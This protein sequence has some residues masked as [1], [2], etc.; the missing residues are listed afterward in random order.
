MAAIIGDQQVEE[1]T[2]SLGREMFARMRGSNPRIWQYA[3][4]LERILN[5]CMQD[6]W[7][8]VQAFRFVDVLPA[9]QNDADIARHLKEYFVLPEHAR[10]G[11]SRQVVHSGPE[12]ADQA[13]RELDANSSKSWMVR[14]VS[15]LMNFRSLHSPLAKMFAFSARTGAAVMAGSFIPGSNVVEAERALRKL[16]KK[17]QA[18]T[19]D[20]LG[21]AAVS[22]VEAEVYHQIYMDLISELPRHAAEWSAVPL[23]DEGD[24]KQIPRVNVSVK[25][26]S[27]YPGF[28]PIAAE[29]AKKRAKEILRPLL[30][31][32]MEQGVHLHIDMEHYAIKDLTLD[33][34]EELFMEDE[35]RDYPHFGI[36]L[37]AYLKDGDKDAARTVEYAQRRGTP[38]WVRLV[39]GAYWD[40]ETVWAAQRHWPVPV[41]EQ[42]WESD[43]CYERMARLI[44]ENYQHV[45]G[46]FASHNVRSLCNAI[47]LRRLLEVPGW[48]FEL[49]MLFGMGDP[50]KAAALQMGQRCRIYTPYGNLLNGMAYFI[51]RL[52]ENTANESFLRQSG[53]ENVDE[54]V[55]LENPD[56]TGGKTTPPEKPAVIRYELEEPIMDPFENVANTDFGLEPNREQMQAG[57]AQIR[58]ELGG[59]TRC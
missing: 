35:F 37:Q 30:R 55:L 3:W 14:T 16:R 57:L 36:V 13:L 47:A 4:W 52:L 44:L 12:Q 22:G 42:K 10:N 32:S 6:E 7:F 58:A 27:L 19:I 40:S 33:L 23:V 8:K 26:T 28:D 31:K 43:A 20:V 46:A 21:E 48:A 51:R 45:H 5:I 39:K 59:S 38:I 15:H 2:Q 49:Q 54:A 18:F 53:D 25:L 34:C 11:R 24:G 1:L 41:W 9:M 17:R 56:V 29:P 50:M